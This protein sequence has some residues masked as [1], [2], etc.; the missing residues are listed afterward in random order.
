MV[1]PA[2]NWLQYGGDLVIALCHGSH[3]IYLRMQTGLDCQAQDI[4]CF[5]TF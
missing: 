5:G 1:W 2:T 4:S 3:H